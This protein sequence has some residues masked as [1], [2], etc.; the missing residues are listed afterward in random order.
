M[1][2]VK[3]FYIIENRK[4]IKMNFHDRIKAIKENPETSQAGSKWTE[5]EENNLLVSI[6][7]GID[8]SDIAKEHKRTEGGISSRIRH[9]AVDMITNKGKEIDD[10]C[11]YLR[12]SKDEVVEILRRVKNKVSKPIKPNIHET[13]HETT[14]DKKTKILDV[15]VEIRDA[16]LRIESQM[17]D[18]LTKKEVFS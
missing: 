17:N 10:V 6:E 18:K 3:V 1:K 11:E 15:F 14:N 4:L 5:E 12:L 2:I 7:K 9:I 16:I 13:L 8:I